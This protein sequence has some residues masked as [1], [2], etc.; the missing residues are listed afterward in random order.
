MIEEKNLTAVGK[1]QKTHALKGELNVILDIDPDFFIDD[2]PLIVNIDGAFVPFYIESVR[3]K[4]AT[5]SLVKLEGIDNLDEAKVLVNSTIFVDRQ[6]LKDYFEDNGEELFLE[7]DLTGYRVI[8]EKEGEVGTILRV[9]DSTQNVLF[10]IEDKE[11]EEI[12]IPV[13]D[14]FIVAI[15]EDKQEIIATLPE[16]LLNLNRKEK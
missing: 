12:Y 6:K 5:T 3:G 14:D 1:F 11:G 7:D 16:E 9:D 4:G 15:D 8:D 2:N 13:A 10:V